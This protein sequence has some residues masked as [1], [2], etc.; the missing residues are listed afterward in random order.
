MGDL[1]HFVVGA[2]LDLTDA[3]EAKVGFSEAPAGASSSK[4][5]KSDR[6][7]KCNDERDDANLNIQ[8]PALN[9][10][11]ED[12]APIHPHPLQ[13]GSSPAAAADGTMP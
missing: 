11:I 3:S 8:T 13:I 12:V 4:T 1:S 2:N 5:D 7:G 9:L 10:D 6:D